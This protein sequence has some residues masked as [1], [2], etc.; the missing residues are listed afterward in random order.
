MVTII[1]DV[2]IIFALYFSSHLVE[3]LIWRDIT[4]LLLHHQVF[5]II[6]FEEVFYSVAKCSPGA[7]RHLS[8]GSSCVTM[9]RF[10][11]LLAKISF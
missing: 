2:L 9:L 11:L 6:M 10:S 7:S 4:K 5:D 8:L 1:K 3:E